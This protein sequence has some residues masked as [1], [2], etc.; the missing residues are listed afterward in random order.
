MRS[1]CLIAI[2]LLLTGASAA[3]NIGKKEYSP[4]PLPAVMYGNIVFKQVSVANSIVPS[5]RDFTIMVGSTLALW[6]RTVTAYGNFSS[7]KCGYKIPNIPARMAFTVF[8][9]YPPFNKTACDAEV[10]KLGT[11]APVSEFKHGQQLKYDPVVS[12][13]RCDIYR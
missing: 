7:G 4:A 1:L 6:T 3:Q 8:V 2:V 13:F 12:E 5:C 11:H 10:L 9:Y